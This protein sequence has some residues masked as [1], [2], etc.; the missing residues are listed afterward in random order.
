MDNSYKKGKGRKLNKS[1][2]LNNNF[3]INYFENMQK[4][5]R[6]FSSSFLTIGNF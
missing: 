2:K 5:K 3:R 4:T 6:D 1:R